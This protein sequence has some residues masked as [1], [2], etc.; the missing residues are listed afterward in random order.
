VLRATD[1]MSAFSKGGS[2]W[3][4]ISGRMKRRTGL[5]FAQHFR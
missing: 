2:I 4:Q 1:W 3:R 5:N